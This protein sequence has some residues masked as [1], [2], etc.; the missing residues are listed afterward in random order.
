M[1][2][3]EEIMGGVVK[4]MAAF[5]SSYEKQTDSLIASLLGRK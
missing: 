2:K 3:F 1:D 5:R 4:E